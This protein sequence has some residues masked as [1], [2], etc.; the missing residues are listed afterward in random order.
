MRVR[1]LAALS[2]A[3]P[4]SM[5]SIARLPSWHSTLNSVMSIA[6]KSHSAVH[7]VAHVS[8]SSAVTR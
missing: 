4:R 3:A 7:G 5:F 6:L 2:L 1:V 8:G